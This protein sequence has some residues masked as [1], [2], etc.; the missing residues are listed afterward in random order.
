M[1]RDAKSRLVPLICDER[2]VVELAVFAKNKRALVFLIGAQ[3]QIEDQF[4]SRPIS[5]GIQIECIQ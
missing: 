5:V 2:M 3:L 1:D 4:L